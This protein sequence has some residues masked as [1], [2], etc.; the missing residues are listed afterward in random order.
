MSAAPGRPKQAR[1]GARQGEATSASTAL[2][3]LWR[4]LWL[5]T[6]LLGATAHAHKGSDAY[7]TLHRAG[8]G[9]GSAPLELSLSIALKDLDLLVPVDANGDA[10]IT[11]SE[12]QAVIP[13]VLT[14]LDST[15]QLDRPGCDLPWRFDALERRSDGAYLKLIAQ[16]QCVGN[17]APG[18]RYTLYRNVDANHR[19]IVTGRVDGRDVLRTASPQQEHAIALTSRSE[20]DIDAAPKPSNAKLTPTDQGRWQTVL[21][22]SSLGLHHLLEGYD[23]MAFLLALVLPLRLALG[24]RANARGGA[25]EASS[26]GS[27][28]AWRALIRT[29]TA[30]TVGHSITL[31]L[32]TFGY[33]EVSPTW[34]EPVIAASIGITALLNLYPVRALRAEVLALGFGMVHGFGFAGLLQ[35]AAAPSGLLPWALLGFNLGVEAGQLLAVSGWVTLSQLFQRRS[36][37]PLVVVR[38]GSLG[39][40]A[41]ATLWLWQRVA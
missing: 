26:A 5:V 27:N 35:E 18:L 10:R 8:A 25:V 4:L 17:P 6:L 16:T 39:L 23:H 2:K 40:T 21:A 3:P 31:M 24:R 12:V 13:A 28:G 14:L 41:M 37:Y 20:P 32:A 33:T 29:V 1:T 30:F 22:Y 15:A 38:G 34:V 11:W 7:L 9:T 19:L 36:W